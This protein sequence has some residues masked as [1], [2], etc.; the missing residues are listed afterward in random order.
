MSNEIIADLAGGL[1]ATLPM[2]GDF[3][4]EKLGPLLDKYMM[5]NPAVS[6]EDQHRCFR[7]LSDAI[8]SGLAGVMQI[9][10]LHGGGSPVMENI[11]TL[12]YYDLEARKNIAKELAGISLK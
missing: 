5:R 7:A 11:A 3:Y 10:G 9:A 8:C 6:A 2:E 1:P 12:G 4:H